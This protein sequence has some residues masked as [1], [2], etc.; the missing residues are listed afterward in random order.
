[1]SKNILVFGAGPG[2]SMAIARRFGQEGFGVTLVSRQVEKLENEIHALQQSGINVHS[3]IADVADPNGVRR[4]IEEVT[5]QVGLPEIVVFNASAVEVRDVLGLNWPTVRTLNEINIGGGFHVAQTILPEYLA[6]NKG[7]L[8]YTGG[9][10]ALH[11]HPEWVSLSIGKAGL[12]N[13]AQA[14]A[15]RV[16]GTDVHVATVTVCGFVQES[17]SKYNPTAI[18]QIYWDLYQESPA[19]YRSEVIY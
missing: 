3:M 10:Q 4:I 1:M 6:Q 7:C 15:K 11:P 5:K 2:I 8:I 18:A 9:G 16:E 13:L 12:R 17:D 19:A 14:L